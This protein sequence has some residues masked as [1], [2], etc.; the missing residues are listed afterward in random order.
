MPDPALEP[1]FEQARAAVRRRDYTSAAQL[2]R[3][4][5]AVDGSSHE[6]LEGLAMMLFASGDLSGA[7]EQFQRLTLVQPLVARHY[8]NLGAIFNRQG[9]HQKAVDALRKRISD[10]EARIAER[11]AQVKDLE[12]AMSAPGF[13]DDRE[14]SKQAADR[15]QALMWE[16]GDLIGQWE[17]LQDHASEH[18]PQPSS[19]QASES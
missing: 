10:L 11:E 16:V 12:A 6:A 3:D 2:Y 8:V 7:I 14:K 19:G 15:H 17:A 5:L 18:A 4:A 13:Y 9:E 1:L